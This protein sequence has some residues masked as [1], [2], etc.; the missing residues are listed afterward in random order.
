MLLMQDR[1]AAQYFIQKVNLDGIYIN[2]EK[3]THPLIVMPH[4]IIF[5]WKA[6]SFENLNDSDFELLLAEKVDIILLGVGEAG[7]KLPSELYYRLLEK[8]LIIE[9]MSLAAA[10]R[11][12]AVLSSEGRRVAAALL[13]EV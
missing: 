3:Y 7:K 6:T 9:S 1:N 8:K 4:K 12:Y 2:E 5:P 10:C 11:T 13:F